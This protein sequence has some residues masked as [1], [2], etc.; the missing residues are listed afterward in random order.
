MTDA[1]P[2]WRNRIAGFAHDVQDELDRVSQ[3]FGLLRDHER[4][5]E[6]VGFRSHGS[7]TRVLVQGRVVSCRRYAKGAATDS[8]WTNLLNTYRRIDSDPLAHA[9][10]TVTVGGTSRA[11]VADDEGFFREWVDLDAPLDG[12]KAWAE[13]ELTLE[14]VPAATAAAKPAQALVRIPAGTPAFGVISDLDDT[15]IQS[16]VTSILQAMRTVMLGN[17]LTRLPFPGVAAFYH[18]LEAGNDG[19]RAN[20]IYYVSSSPWNIY[21]VISDFMDFQ[22]IPPGSIHLRDWD[23]DI[24]ALR[25]S[26]LRSHKEPIIREIL[27]L[28]PSLPF[29][30]IGDDSQ[31]DPEI[32]RAILAD[33]PGRIH[34]IYIRN[35]RTDAERKTSVERLADEVTAAGS[36]LILAADTLAAA[37]HAAERGWIAAESLA[38]IAEDKHADEGMNARKSDVPADASAAPADGIG[39]TGDASLKDS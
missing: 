4:R 9:K 36:S 16:R 17:A 5:H 2:S 30:L 12:S 11:I 15:V 8:T 21:D 27:D 14:A 29:I 37:K 24:G 6:I 19:T 10:L 38:S 26:R 20:P 31:H 39:D 35:V 3:H 34:A 25:S 32:Y 18:A 7:T 1:K 22:G 23:V 33:Y 13:A 28:H